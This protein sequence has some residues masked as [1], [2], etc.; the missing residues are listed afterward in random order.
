M[1]LGRIISAYVKGGGST[2]CKGVCLLFFLCLFL[3]SSSATV[4]AQDFGEDRD[5]LVRL[6]EAKSIKLT[7]IGGAPFRIVNGPARFLHNNTYMLCDSAAWD[8][9]ANT[10]DAMGHVQIIQKDTYLTSDLATYISNENLVQFRGT[11]VKLYNKKGDKL[12]TRF[13]DYNTADSVATFYNGGAM[14]SSKGDIVEGLEG[15]YDATQRLFMFNDDVCMYS[16]SIFLKSEMVEYHSN[17]E[18]AMFAENTVAWKG[19][20]TLFSNNMEYSTKNKMLVLKADNYIAT[21]DQELWAGWIDYYRESGNAELYGNVQVRDQ[22]Q[23]AIIMGDKGVYVQKPLLL[24][25]TENAAAGMYSEEKTGIDS[26]TNQPIYKRDTLFLAGDTL[27]MWQVPMY[28]VDSSEVSR[29]VQRRT[30]ADTDPMV[31]INRQNKAYLDA[32]KR[33]KALLD[34]PVPLPPKRPEVPKKEEENV[35]VASDSLKVKAGLESPS[36]DIG[37]DSLQLKGGLDSLQMKSGLDSL[38]MARDSVPPLDTTAVTFMSVFHKVKLFRSDLRGA[39]DSLIYTTIDSIARFYKDPILWNEEKTQFTSDSIQ[40]SIRNNEIYKAN[41]IENAFIISQEDSIHFHQIKSTEMI[42]YF[43]DNDVYRFDALGGVQA[44]FFLSEKDSVVTLMNQKE[45]RLMT[46]KIVNQEIERVRYI[47]SVKSDVI[48]TYKLPIEKMRLRDFNWQADRMPKSRN[49]LTT[50]KV[51]PTDRGKLSRHRFPLYNQTRAFFPESYKDILVLSSSITQKI[52]QEDQERLER[53]RQKKDQ[54]QLLKEDE[55]HRKALEEEGHQMEQEKNGPVMIY[56]KPES[57]EKSL[58]AKPDRTQ[59]K[60]PEKA[61]DE[62]KIL[63]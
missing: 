10:I 45:C 16:D 49:E 47:E 27:K 21:Q 30:L 52:R 28:Q 7:E 62:N 33:N 13:L 46:A 31:E 36:K 20:D 41:L 8:V 56:N 17:Q 24:Y 3:F 43:K 25:M 57:Q 9:N 15:M 59:T 40:L 60:K 35:P 54:E 53:E 37:L 38:S 63:K 44:M 11:E 4:S 1:F 39:C 5:S 29:A 48:P 6:I 58:D 18:V 22:A 23:S 32:Y 51:K 14:R 50:R 34:N 61:L 55:E 2:L 12:I 42:A 26:L 19:R